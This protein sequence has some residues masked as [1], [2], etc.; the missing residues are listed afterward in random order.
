[1]EEQ[2]GTITHLIAI[3]RL[4]GH[5]DAL[6]AWLDSIKAEVREATSGDDSGKRAT[7]DG[8]G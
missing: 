1:M 7:A 3:G 2:Q 5:V 6:E 4:L 8:A